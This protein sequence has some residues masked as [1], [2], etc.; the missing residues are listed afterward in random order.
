[1]KECITYESLYS[2]QDIEAVMLACSTDFFLN[3]RTTLRRE[4]KSYLRNFRNLLKL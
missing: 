2:Q 1:M 3:N 4:S